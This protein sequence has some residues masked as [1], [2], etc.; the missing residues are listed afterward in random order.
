MGED[1]RRTDLRS[2][3]PDSL[4]AAL[5]P[6]LR[7]ECGGRLSAIEWF[8]SNW[9]HSGATTGFATWTDGEGREIGAMVKLPVGGAEYRWTTRLGRAEAG[10]DAEGLCTP[11]VFASGTSV[12]G[13]D[14]A[15]LVLERLE[16]QPLTG[17]WCREALEDLVRAAVDF[18][19][20]AE[21]AAPPGPP[22][23]P[24]DWAEVMG[25]AREIVKTAQMPEAQRWNEALHRV[26]KALPR[27]ALKWGARPINSWCHGDLHPGN[28]MRRAEAREGGGASRG[29]VL[30]DLGL[31]HAGH[32]VEDAVYLERQF[33]GKPEGLHDVHPV[34]LLAHCRRERSMPTEGDYGML[35][36]V[37]RVLMAACVPCF[38]A[39]E[40]HPKYVH[41]A[42][43]VIE[44]VLPQVSK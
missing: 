11:R 32:W 21:R 24:P 39:R 17:E 42:L 28:A 9:Q 14:L 3:D 5:A 10:E 41:A 22:P 16:G 31:V 19:A 7:E 34:K 15:W 30:I 13:Y 33:W 38:L 27:L 4:S 23:A 40:G 18:Q 44:R 8:R 20:R 36:N 6:A 26:Q 1:H 37:R 29:C 25:K 35:A 2:A 12:A 43:E